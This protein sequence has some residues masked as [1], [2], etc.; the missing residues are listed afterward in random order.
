MN[1]NF[2]DN[3]LFIENYIPNYKYKFLIQVMKIFHSYQYICNS[4]NLIIDNE[5]N[6]IKT[7]EGKFILG[8]LEI[9]KI[10]DLK[11]ILEKSL[12]MKRLS[13]K[14]TYKNHTKHNIKIFIEFSKA[15]LEIFLN[16]SNDIEKN[17]FFNLLKKNYISYSLNSNINDIMCIKQYSN[18]SVSKTIEINKN[19]ELSLNNLN[20]NLLKKS[21]IR[22]QS[23]KEIIMFNG[24]C[25]LFNINDNIANLLKY[26]IFKFKFRK[27]VFIYNNSSYCNII[28]IKINKYANSFCGYNNINQFNQDNYFEAINYI[29]TNLIE[30]IIIFDENTL[31]KVKYDVNSHDIKNLW[32]ISSSFKIIDLIS[33]IQINNNIDNK[34]FL[35]INNLHQLSKIITPISNQIKRINKPQTLELNLV[36]KTLIETSQ[37]IVFKETDL[38]KNLENVCPICRDSPEKFIKF[39]CGHIICSECFTEFYNIEKADEFN[40]E[41][42]ECTQPIKNKST[43]IYFLKKDCCKFDNDIV[44]KFIHNIS[45]FINKY[46]TTN[47]GL[48]GSDK[49]SH[50]LKDLILFMYP[51]RQVNIY[52]EYSNLF[53]LKNYCFITDFNDVSCLANSK[54][55]ILK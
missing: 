10:K 25:V 26:H 45:K 47:I 37:K 54:I 4:K 27:S 23:C 24:G 3:N 8:L 16:K 53:S 52:N 41:C 15:N 19:L 13:K 9:P 36:L 12:V 22:N 5:N 55:L 39:G 31:K 1:S 40:I 30:N 14:A 42:V 2:Y 35:N 46:L 18:N 49:L 50:F 33:L 32:W 38:Q 21:I 20:F 28:K 11:I 6:I 34:Y 17:I 44:S 51:S 7:G 29:S 48:I 43:E